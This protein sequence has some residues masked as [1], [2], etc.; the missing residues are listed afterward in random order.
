[1]SLLELEKLN[2]HYGAIHAVRDVSLSIEEGQVVTLIG[3][4]GAGKSS[5][6][7]SIMGLTPS[8]AARMDLRTPDGKTV[9]LQDRPTEDRV[10]MGIALSPEGRRILPHLTA[11]ENLRLGAWT[12]NDAAGVEEDLEHVFT[13]FPRLRERRRQKGGTLSGGEQQML[14][15]GRALMSRPNLLML[16]EP[17]L[18]L[19]PILVEEVFNIIRAINA[20]G[21]TI[22]LVEQNAWAALK[23]AHRAYV[24]EVGAV[25]LS[26]TGEE[27]LNDARV[28]SAY[29]GG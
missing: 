13:L 27:L 16:D 5:V 25:A 2:V 9:P 20:Q 12:R 14:S 18:G 26:G 1:M 21:R 22:L 8:R 3:A 29:L 7:R 17:S 6:I 23:I 24:L 10:K 28:R 11:E 15:V 19:A 4:N